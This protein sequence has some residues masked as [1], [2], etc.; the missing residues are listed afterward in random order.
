MHRRRREEGVGSL[1]RG[2][3]QREGNIEAPGHRFAVYEGCQE[4]M[5]IDSVH[6]NARDDEGEERTGESARP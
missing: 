2:P 3:R 6:G 1:E 5:E 4:M